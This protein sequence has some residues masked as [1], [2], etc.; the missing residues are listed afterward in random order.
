MKIPISI[1]VVL[2]FFLVTQSISCSSDLDFNQT[3]NLKL[4][5]TY[6]SNLVYFDIPA[7]E[8][9]T[10]GSE[11]QFFNRFTTDIFRKTF[12]VNSLNKVDFDFEINN[13]INRAYIL[14]VQ[15]LDLKGIRLDSIDIS[16]PAYSGVVNVII[17]KEI[18]QGKRLAVL[19]KTTKIEMALRMISGAPIS[20]SSAGNINLRSGL[21]AYFVIQ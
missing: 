16:I 14:E 17:Q 19:K 7:P 9:V 5:P 4:A 13:T 6:V 3:K 21:T 20:E 12:F 1:Q 10:A 18:F 11:N 8:F 2:F 15:L